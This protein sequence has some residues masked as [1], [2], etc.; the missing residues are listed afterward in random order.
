[1]PGDVDGGRQMYLGRERLGS[2]KSPISPIRSMNYNSE[3][4]A[5]IEELVQRIRKDY[6]EFNDTQARIWEIVSRYRGEAG[7]SASAVS[8]LV[9]AL[10]YLASDLYDQGH[11]AATNFAIN[12][13]EGNNVI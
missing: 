4:L 13:M 3:D 2:R 5:A 10:Y 8:Y 1:M 6:P 11:T 7:L 9:S 12:L